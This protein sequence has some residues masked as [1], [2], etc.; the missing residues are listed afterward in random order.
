M[1]LT[2]CSLI[3][4]LLDASARFHFL[5][6]LFVP[7]THCEIVNFHIIGCGVCSNAQDTATLLDHT[8][9]LD[10]KSYLCGVDFNLDRQAGVEPTETLANLINCVQQIGFTPMC[11]NVRSQHLLVS[12]GACKVPCAADQPW[13]NTPNNPTTCAKNPCISCTETPAILNGFRAF[14]GREPTISGIITNAAQ[15]CDTF[16]EVNLDPCPGSGAL[17]D[18]SYAPSPPTNLQ[19]PSSSGF[20]SFHSG[21][22]MAVA[23]LLTIGAVLDSL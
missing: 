14:A 23:A 7:R 9:D 19:A 4:F 12:G 20:A 2:L 13:V 1:A 15:P 18:T 8:G 11:A 5:V 21:G 22:A 16:P 3:W 6:L 17:D 10:E